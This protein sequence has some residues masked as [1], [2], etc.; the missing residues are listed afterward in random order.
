MPPSATRVR[1]TGHPGYSETLPRLPES[2]AAARRLTRT[3]LACWDLEELAGDGALIVT[4][5]VTNAV[6]HARR[7]S[8][9]VVVERTAERTV[10]L[11]VSDRSRLRP[12][13]RRADTDEAG[14]RGLR[15]VAALTVDWGV[16][17]RRWGKVVWA[18]L[19]AR[20]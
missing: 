4:E 6:R 20:R 8:I 16:C 14:G 18:A 11:A 15:V 10:R 2:P 13:L 5:L 17:E 1:P 3:A 9:R 12:V 19:E 7:G